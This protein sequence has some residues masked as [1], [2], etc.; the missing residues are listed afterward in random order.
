MPEHTAEIDAPEDHGFVENAGWTSVCACGDLTIRSRSDYRRHIAAFMG[1][2]KV[3]L[4]CGPW[5]GRQIALTSTPPVILIG[6]DRYEAIVD[7]DT[8]ENLGAYLWVEAEVAV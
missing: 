1:K 6:S 5:S 2:T 8:G 4:Y 3:Y 7:P